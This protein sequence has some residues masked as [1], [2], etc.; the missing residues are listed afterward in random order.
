MQIDEWIYC[1][2][3]L[4]KC[5][6][7]PP[8]H[9]LID[10]DNADAF[11][12]AQLLRDG[13]LLIHLLNTLSPQIIN[14]NDVI[15]KPGLS[16]FLSLRN[17]RMFLQTCKTHFGLKETDLFTPEDLFDVKNF[18]KVICTLS[19]LS[20]LSSVQDLSQGGFPPGN[21]VAKFDPGYYNTLEE[22][23]NEH[24]VVTSSNPY[25]YTETGNDIYGSLVDSA[26]PVE[27]AVLKP[28]NE[29]E[30]CMEEIVIT[31]KS[32]INTLEMIVSGFDRPL[33]YVLDTEDHTLLFH[34][35]RDLLA[36][37]T[38]FY[39]DLKKCIASRDNNEIATVFL[40]W[41]PKFLIYGN[42][43]GKLDICLKRLQ[44]IKKQNDSVSHSIQQCE[45]LQNNGKFTLNSIL[46]VP[47]QRVLKYHLLI[48]GLI[49][50]NV[51]VSA[52]VVK[53]TASLESLKDLAT[54]VNE[55][56][57]DVEAIEAILNIDKSIFGLKLPN[58]S[59]T[60]KDYGKIIKDGPLKFRT[61]NDKKFH[62]RYIFLFNKLVL[63]CKPRGD[64]FLYKMSV[65][66]KNMHFSDQPDILKQ[67]SV[68]YV[69]VCSTYLEWNSYFALKNSDGMEYF[70]VTKL[71]EEKR[72]WENA[73]SKVYDILHPS[74]YLS[75]KDEFDLES[76]ASPAYCDVCQK[77]LNGCFFQG[78]R[79]KKS[80]ITCHK[81]CITMQEKSVSVPPLPPR[82]PEIISTTS[83]ASPQL[84]NNAK[85]VFS[86]MEYNGFPPP[87]DKK[88]TLRFNINQEITNV[89][90]E[91]LTWWRGTID[92]R[93]GYF[94]SNFIVDVA[95][96]ST[97][98]S[99]FKKYSWFVGDMGR[100]ES[101][102]RLE[103]TPSGTFMVRIST[104]PSRLGELAISIKFDDT[105]NHIRI[106]KES[107]H[108][109][110]ADCL[111]FPSIPSLI[112]Y[113]QTNSLKYNFCELDTT[114]LF[115]YNEYLHRNSS[116][117]KIVDI[118]DYVFTKL[119]FDEYVL[120]T[121]VVKKVYTPVSEFDLCL[122]YGELVL[123]LGKE[124]HQ[125]DMW[126]GVS[127][128]FIGF[129]PKDFINSLC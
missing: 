115:P 6:V 98:N 82:R 119:F 45:K 96:K 15:R 41:Q 87:P 11:H 21:T 127:N 85:T 106:I 125:R 4:L 7:L 93:T 90:T 100:I 76:I 70:F 1:Y 51:K 42:F 95:E 52:D 35:I 53:L 10:T 62:S 2:K 46:L 17:I 120:Q 18:A 126:R 118:H 44:E 5:K 84:K 74:G 72:K 59:T 78:Y 110:I 3:W 56:T 57:R 24:E 121:G 103:S 9:N 22:L 54:Y 117:I 89:D 97:E 102:K 83:S 123:V 112:V 101:K 13:V 99:A 73:F 8:G 16:R 81:D 129:F 30:Y 68:K 37:H 109:Y 48:K 63:V 36:I 14:M 12:L 66:C 79:G 92:N 86:I 20:R 108:Y 61:E 64:T 33:E 65:S 75:N 114:L 111:T 77:L 29:I 122:K 25:D 124:T 67:K 26:V 39:A 94:P 28:K 60:L 43:C 55:C 38:G 88:E 128:G 107:H 40:D 19:K 47:M 91:N 80:G 69:L 34:L 27:L 58:D 113:Y 116:Q 23:A 31:E 105:T 71:E 49:K 104:N 32:Y 50:F